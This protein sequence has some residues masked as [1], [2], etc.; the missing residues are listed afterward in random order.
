MTEDEPRGSSVAEICGVAALAA[1]T[2]AGHTVG[3]GRV[4]IVVRTVVTE[5]S[6]SPEPEADR[7]GTRDRAESH[8]TYAFACRAGSLSPDARS[9]DAPAK[10]TCVVSLPWSTRGTDTAKRHR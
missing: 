1:A 6:G 4:R 10:S 2:T 7:S 9:R 5:P 3:P 8:R